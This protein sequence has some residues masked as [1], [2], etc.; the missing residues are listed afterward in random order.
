[1]IFTFYVPDYVFLWIFLLSWTSQST[2]KN[3]NPPHFEHNLPFMAV[4]TLYLFYSYTTGLTRRQPEHNRHAF[5]TRHPF[6]LL[7]HQRNNNVHHLWEHL[8]CLF[9]AHLV[10]I[11]SEPVW[12]LR[13]CKT[14]NDGKTRSCR[15][16]LEQIWKEQTSTRSCQLFCWY[17]AD[18][19][20][21][22][23]WRNMQGLCFDCPK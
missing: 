18:T 12:P 6:V 2:V 19:I 3:T 17:E 22:C 16:L 11:G 20:H 4:H 5:A 9:R 7:N 10:Q 14:K 23:V 13:D 1:M 8:D 15:C 21:Q